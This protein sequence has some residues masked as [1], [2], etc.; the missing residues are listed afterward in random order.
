MVDSLHPNELAHDTEAAA[1]AKIRALEKA[2]R[3][4]QKKLKRTQTDLIKLEE[5]NEKKE[6]L[7]RKIIQDLNETEQQFQN[8]ITGTAATTGKDFFPALVQHIA[9][10]LSVAYAVV[11]EQVGN[12]L[13]T[14][15]FWANGTLQPTFAYH[16]AQTPCE[17]TLQEG[18]FYCEC[19]IQKQF[20]PEDLD[21]AAMG[22]ESYLG[23]ALRSEQGKTL[24][25]LCILDQQ[26]IQNPQRAEEIL[27]VFAARASAELERQRAKVSLEQL[28]QELEVK[29]Q[30]RT[31]AL[32][33]SEAQIRAMIGAIPD[34]LLRVTQ[35]GTCLDYLQSHHQT[36]EF[37]R[38]QEHL[39]EVLP[40][41]LLAQQ[42]K[43]I[44]QAISTQQ[45]QVYE[46]VL[47]KNGHAAYEEVRISVLNENEALVMVR[48]ITQRKQSENALRQSQ[49]DLQ[50]A[51]LQMVQS[52]KM[53]SLG[54][55]VAGVAHEINNPL[56][57]LNG[58]IANAQDYV[59]D[60]F[61]HITLYQ[62]QPSLSVPLQNHAK[63]IDL[64][65]VQTDFPKLLNSMEE[66]T[67]RIK[68]ISTSLRTFSRADTTEKIKVDLHEGLAS[69]L[70]ILKYRLKAN[71]YRP[72]IE[73]IQD[74]GDLLEI[75]CFPGQINQ[76]F[77][78]VLANAI[79]MF[80]EAAQKSSFQ[81]LEKHPQRI[82]IQTSVLP[83]K[84]MASIDIC[85]NGAGMS[86]E[87]QAQIFDHLFTT[88]KMGQGTGLGLAIASQIVTETHR[89]Q[90]TVQSE[91]GK[92]STFCIQ[93]PLS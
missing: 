23:I 11:T 91:V 30:E 51:Q 55:L 16:A 45:V 63:A 81:D 17:R 89:G 27:Q 21:L 47:Q 3:V 78:N 62:Q 66:A 26:P 35:D 4:L 18:R 88:K 42:L 22:A 43:A 29:V 90:L 10:T 50:N 69:T 79:D 73:V 36:D 71:Q 25:N 6:S 44:E 82:T 72:A 85:D 56:G 41:D 48:D 15:G 5:T 93:L 67:A 38:I 58:S 13:H 9:E 65:F 54:N 86:A 77:M 74:S 83:T 1:L 61:E 52:E 80:D 60:L 46:H 59:G 34:L 8:L 87:V 49:Q 84:Y 12:E 64:E 20:C 39:S 32:Y 14:L 2:N 31:A 7:L 68:A 40:P 75:E 70:L 92:G 24:G 37:L 19:A 76:V 53:A 28:N 57:F 33:S